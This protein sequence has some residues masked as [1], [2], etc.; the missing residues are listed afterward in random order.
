MP[1]KDIT[2]ILFEM[3][4]RHMPRRYRHYAAECAMM[5][6]A[7]PLPM[8]LSAD[9]RLRCAADSARHAVLLHAAA[10]APP[11]DTR[12]ADA[13]TRL[14]HASYCCMIAYASACLTIF[15]ACPARLVRPQVRQLSAASS[16]CQQLWRA[17]VMSMPIIFAS[18][19]HE[20]ARRAARQQ[21]C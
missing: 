12:E 11:Y 7:A 8:L 1:R 10:E 3:L 21:C 6:I 9:S 20:E 16:T 2:L 14:R 18:P 17:H 5:A 19:W 4:P 13:A 15:F